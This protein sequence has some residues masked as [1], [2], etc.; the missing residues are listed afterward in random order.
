MKKRTL[1]LRR[2]LPAFLFW[3][4]NL[5]FLAFVIFGFAPTILP[6]MIAA[7]WEE[8]LPLIFPI[9]ALILTIIPVVIVSIGFFRL[10]YAPKLLL[11]LGYGVEGPLMIL[12][13]IRLFIFRE[14]NPAMTGLLLAAGIGMLTLLWDLLDLEIDKRG[15]GWQTLRLI[16]TSCLL[17]VGIYAA[18][19]F[20]FYAVAMV[21]IF[22]QGIEEF[23]RNFT[24]NMENF[25][26]DL[27]RAWEDGV[28]WVVLMLL[29]IV[30][31]AYTAT[32]L[33]GLPIAAALIY[34]RTWRRALR[35]YR[36]LS[37]PR[38]TYAIAT[39]LIAVFLVAFAMLNRQPQTRAFELVRIPP[40]T[41][42]TAVSLIDQES[43]IR[44]GLL[45]AYLS[46]M[47]YVSADGS[48]RH[49]Q[50]MYKYGVGLSA[51]RA[52]QVENLYA[53]VARP[54]LYK[55]V[56][57]ASTGTPRWG[58]NSVMQRDSDEAAELYARFFDEPIAEGEKE[59]IVR[60]AKS[61]WNVEQA[62]NQWQQVD[63][64]EVHLLKQ[65][66]TVDEHDGWAEIELHEA[67][68]NVTWQRQEV[69]YYFSLPESAVVTG[70]WLGNSDVKSE[71]FE[72]RVA[73]RGAAQA[74]YQNEVQRRTDPALLEQLGP[75]QYRLRIFPIEPVRW[76]QGEEQ[77]GPP[78]YL[79]MNYRVLA[80]DTGWATPQLSVKRNIF[81]DDETE[82]SLNGETLNL[83]DAWLPA[84]LASTQER[85]NWIHQRVDFDNGQSVLVSRLDG[86]LPQP[87]LNV[88]IVVDRSRSMAVHEREVMAAVAQ[89]EGRAASAELFL[90]AGEYHS[91]VPRMASLDE[92]DDILFFGGMNSADL[93][94]Q[95]NELS[96]NTAYDAV[97]VLTD[98]AGYE[99]GEPDI[100]APAIS[101]PIW[102]IHFGGYPIGYDDGTLQAI[103]ASGGGAALSVSDALAR[104]G[105]ELD[106]SVSDV[107]D[108]YRWLVMES[109]EVDKMSA[110]EQNPDLAPFAARRLILSEMVRQRANLDQVESLD[111]LHAIAVENSIV[112]P[113]SSMLVL[114]NDRQHKLLDELEQ[115]DDRFEREFEE[116]DDTLGIQVT[117]VP[118]PHEYILMALAVGMLLW[119]WRQKRDASV[120]TQ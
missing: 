119:Y 37:S 99:L 36:Q 14:L 60:A 43:V 20:A 27:R 81:W 64:R 56:N 16:G 40:T 12:I 42:E 102:M 100:A 7:I 2:R 68:Q 85:P 59:A 63:D 15:K 18:V 71:A 112:T 26:R 111:Q 97:F 49:V 79:W 76:S 30:L 10:R 84:T 48:V 113:Y 13:A 58:R 61:T 110:V 28:Q 4:W 103:Q 89:L 52:H 34:I 67:Y 82:R 69:L 35:R 51:D 86:E 24:W 92:I 108:G 29:G 6:E 1:N 3:S 90:T 87:E 83:K 114:V 47:R 33:I 38:P 17:L 117:G 120:V 45:N 32:L 73:P 106:R 109:A 118:E 46:P 107:V 66:L 88:A 94:H 80:S 22:A 57:K 116:I 93:L 72:H 5:I 101:R 53:R 105:G 70:L 50:D 21:A 55:P 75:T 104:M 44:A 62:M 54:V 65:S 98:D 115:A 23:F 19:W 78:L 95:F 9:T 25:F 77:A 11:A 91:D 41:N 96:S 8:D 74:V 39:G 31:G